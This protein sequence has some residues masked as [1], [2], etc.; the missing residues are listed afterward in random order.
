VKRV[1]I[2]SRLDDGHVAC[3]AAELNRLGA[4]WIVFDPRAFPGAAGLARSRI[5]DVVD[6]GTTVVTGNGFERYP[7]NAPYERT[8]TTVSTFPVSPAWIAQLAP[9]LCDS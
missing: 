3:L 9:D 5:K 8:I 4:P 7:L 6:A 2:L 1:L